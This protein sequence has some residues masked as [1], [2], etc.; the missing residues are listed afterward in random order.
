[1][2]YDRTVIGYHGCDVETAERVLRGDGFRASVNGYDWLGHGVYFWEYGPDRAWRFALE[3]QRRGL[4]RRPAVVGAVLQLG[5]CF[6]LMDTRFTAELADSFPSFEAWL[7]GK[8]LPMPANR[9]R[10]PDQKLRYLDC[11]V[12][13]WFLS[14]G[15]SRGKGYDSVRGGFTE[16]EPVYAGAGI[17]RESHIQLSIRN[18]ACIVG[19][20]RPVEAPDHPDPGIFTAGEKSAAGT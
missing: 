8:G 1:M 10:T 4:V 17:H 2:R 20:F 5:R 15:D 7:A 3:Q 6:D 9:G 13:N 11:S 12:L 14:E 19:V 18:P 16:G